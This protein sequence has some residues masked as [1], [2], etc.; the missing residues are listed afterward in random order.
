MLIAID[1]GNT[2][3]TLG[4]YDG[5]VLGPR[6]RLSTGD[7]KTADEFGLL[8][9]GLF[10]RSGVDIASVDDAAI[11]SVVPQ[12][13]GAFVDACRHY[14]KCEPLVV[15]GECKTGVAILCD[16]PAEVGADRIVDA[17]A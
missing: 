14:L 1:I 12:L 2:N 6:W 13:T 17:A 7:E 10:R 15:D 5:E 9:R 3:I 4:L 11:A 8:I 16:N